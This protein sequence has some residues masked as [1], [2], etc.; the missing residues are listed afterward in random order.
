MEETK[1]GNEKEITERWEKLGLIDS[2]DDNAK[3][4]MAHAFEKLATSLISGEFFSSRNIREIET[5]CFPITR[6]I[7][8]L[9]DNYNKFT[10]KSVRDL[11]YHI[12]VSLIETFDNDYN[13]T[14][15]RCERISINDYEA[16]FCKEFAEKYSKENIK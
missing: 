3:I 8:A 9:N 15:K 6:M 7:L 12:L 13:E 16:E 11:A 14:K 4:I 5:L 10:T 1:M 2:L